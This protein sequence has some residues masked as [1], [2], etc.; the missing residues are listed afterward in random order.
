MQ[1]CLAGRTALQCRHHLLNRPRGV[2]PVPQSTHKPRPPARR[3][4]RFRRTGF[5][6]VAT[7]GS[8]KYSFVAGRRS[9]GPL[10]DF[11]N[12]RISS[13]CRSTFR[14][15]TCRSTSSS[16][17][18]MGLAVGFI[19]G[20]FGIGGG[21]LMT[22]LLIFLGISP[23]RRRGQRHHPH[24]RFLLLRR[25]ELLAPQRR[26]S[27]ARLHAARGR[28]YRHRRRRLAVHDAALARPARHHYRHLL[29]AAAH[30]RR[31]PDGDRERARHRPHAAGQAG[32][33]P[34]AGLPTPGCTAC[35]SSSAS[36][37]RASMSRPFRSGP[38][39]SSSA[40]SARSWASA[41]ASCWC[42]C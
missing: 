41:A 13:P 11:S 22:P 35:R 12:V 30:H 37:A 38:S 28:H 34:P 29:R 18:T 25:A 21:F 2:V 27:R 40:S 39:A 9:P 8:I 15:Q 33:T 36:S 7:A 42:R 23:A 32:R 24:R 19:S 26:R 10:C 31:R 5:R 17:S 20:M 14:S 16:F 1:A 3:S 4:R 6:S